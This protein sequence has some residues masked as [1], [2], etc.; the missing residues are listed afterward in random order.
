MDRKANRNRKIKAK[1]KSPEFRIVLKKAQRKR[2]LINTTRSTTLWKRKKKGQ[3]LIK[4]AKLRQKKNTHRLP[5]KIIKPALIKKKKKCKK[6]NFDTRSRKN[7]F[8]SRMEYSSTKSNRSQ[9]S[10][11]LE[12][13]DDESPK[14]HSII[15][16]E[17]KEID[18]STKYSTA[19]KNNFVLPSILTKNPKT[20]NGTKRI[21]FHDQSQPTYTYSLKFERSKLGIMSTRVIKE[22]VNL[23]RQKCESIAGDLSEKGDLEITSTTDTPHKQTQFIQ[24]MAKSPQVNRNHQL[25]TAQK[26]LQTLKN[27]PS[28]TLKRKKCRRSLNIRPL[29]K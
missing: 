26:L 13:I 18:D 10:I 4:E 19:K 29:K 21:T 6:K 28:K 2:S 24:K 12:E 8:L 17:E 23:I 14:K 1:T 16:E 9:R 15:I 25:S 22:K 27:S 5:V 3:D 20:K 11:K 7:S